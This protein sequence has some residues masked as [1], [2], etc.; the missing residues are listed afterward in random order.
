[1]RFYA[2]ERLGSPFS[3]ENR[4]PCWY[5]K[6]SAFIRNI[7]LVQKH[8][9]GISWYISR[10]FPLPL[11]RSEVKYSH[12]V[13]KWHTKSFC[14]CFSNFHFVLQMLKYTLW[15]Q[16]KLWTIFGERQNAL[17]EKL[18]IENFF[19]VEKFQIAKKILVNCLISILAHIMGATSFLH[20]CLVLTELYRYL[21]PNANVDNPKPVNLKC[22]GNHTCRSLMW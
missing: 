20:R 10:N 22:Y 5:S 6:I 1:M 3:P 19:A 2:A 21:S 12:C 11:C 15:N 4:D 18:Q 14:L 8:L 13:E 9:A 7:F 17:W 16:H